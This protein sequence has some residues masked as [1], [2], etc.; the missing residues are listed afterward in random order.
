MFLP[1]TIQNCGVFVFFLPLTSTTVGKLA[2]LVPSILYCKCLLSVCTQIPDCPLVKRA[3]YTV[4][5]RKWSLS[6][7]GSGQ[8]SLVEGLHI[9]SLQLRWERRGEY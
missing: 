7:V 3:S 1:S 2:N 4:A 5:E 6:I 9:P 8:C